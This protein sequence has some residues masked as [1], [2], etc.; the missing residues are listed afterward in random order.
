MDVDVRAF[1]F[2]RGLFPAALEE[3]RG[4]SIDLA[5][6]YIPAEAF[7]KR[8]VDTS[9]KTNGRASAHVKSAT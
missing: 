9:S 2:E 6:K 5:P 3:T 8:A 4:K 7:D 1:E